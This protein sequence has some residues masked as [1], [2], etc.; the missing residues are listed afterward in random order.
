MLCI[1]AQ[2]GVIS[3]LE[4]EKLLELLVRKF[5]EW[6]AHALDELLTDFF[7]SDDQIEDYLKLVND[8]SLRSFTLMLA[9]TSAGADGLDLKENVALQKAYAIW[10]IEKH[11]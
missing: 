4:E 2:D 3:E 11:A 9:E 8:E 10:G 7:D 6:N 5:P 1:C